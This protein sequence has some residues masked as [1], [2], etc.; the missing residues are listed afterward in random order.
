MTTTSR[1]GPQA[2]TGRPQGTPSGRRPYGQTRSPRRG[3]RRALRSSPQ[4]PQRG[5]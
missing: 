5:V 3:R 1:R 2:W 4:R